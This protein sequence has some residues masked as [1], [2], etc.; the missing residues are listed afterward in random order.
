VAA[1]DDEIH[2]VSAGIRLQSVWYGSVLERR[3]DLR[4]AG[5]SALR[6]EAVEVGQNSVPLLLE[7]FDRDC[8]CFRGRLHSEERTGGVNANEPDS[9]P[10]TL[11]DQDGNPNRFAIEPRSIRRDH[12]HLVHK[13]PLWYERQCVEA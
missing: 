13:D 8:R 10:A 4:V 6:G 12:D 2:L 9:C 1:Y 7:H 3:I 5:I 11:S